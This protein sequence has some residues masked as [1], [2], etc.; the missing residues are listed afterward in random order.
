MP[1]TRYA[2]PLALALTLAA[3]SLAAPAQQSTAQEDPREVMTQLCTS[4]FTALERERPA[5]RR[6]PGRAVAVLEELLAPRLDM[7]YTARLVLGSRGRSASPEQR[8]RFAHALYR[9]LLET[10]AGSIVEWTPERLNIL[11]LAADPQALQAVVRTQVLR[12]DG[13]RVAVDYRLRRTPQ[14]WKVFDV[15]VDGASYV[16]TWHEDLDTE[17]EQRGLEAATERLEKRSPPAAR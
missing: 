17:I 7:E 9:S 8:Q 15:V 3:V 1:R 12:T 5:L 14:G 13:T 4:L 10:Y 11:P 6:E 16:R 2:S